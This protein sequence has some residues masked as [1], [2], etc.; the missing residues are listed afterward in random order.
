MLEVDPTGALNVK[1]RLSEIVKILGEANPALKKTAEL[2]VETTSEGQ[3]DTLINNIRLVTEELSPR[4]N[5][6]IVALIKPVNAF[7]AAWREGGADLTSFIDTVEDRLGIELPGVVKTN[8][9]GAASI[10][11]NPEDILDNLSL[12]AGKFS[13]DFGAGAN[14]LLGGFGLDLDLGAERNALNK[15]KPR[16]GLLT[17]SGTGIR[18]GFKSAGIEIIS[19]T[20]DIQRPGV[21]N[22]NDFSTVIHINGVIDPEQVGSIVDLK[23]GQRNQEAAIQFTPTEGVP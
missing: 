15:L 12:G 16:P 3:W 6:A 11:R 19:D 10:F 13:S 18:R 20:G 4:M 5:K 2:M 22:Q 8:L 1:Q 9:A 7:F 23:L 17:G 21:I 14:K